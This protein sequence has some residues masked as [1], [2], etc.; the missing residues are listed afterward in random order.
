MSSAPAAAKKKAAPKKAATAAATTGTT[1][2]T[3]KTS[4]KGVVPK[5]KNSNKKKKLQ[6]KK[7]AGSSVAAVQ[8][9]RAFQKQPTIFVGT[10]TAPLRNVTRRKP[11]RTT[12]F[13]KNVGLGYK[14]PKAAKSGAYVDKKC[15]FT[16][17]VSIRGRI[18]RGK[19][20]KTH[21]KRTVVLRRDYLH[22]IPKYKRYEKRHKN[23]AAHVSPAFRLRVGDVVEVGQCR[24]L[25]K[26]VR[27]NVFKLVKSASSDKGFKK[28]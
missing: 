15:P 26:T 8:D 10:R 28:F 13:W 3:S 1:G 6:Q 2:T 11:T 24:P 5:R 27:F 21:M 16:G 22:Y 14:V 25:S 9:E 23:L 17:D 4:A 12:R 20:V 18:L 7:V 19:V